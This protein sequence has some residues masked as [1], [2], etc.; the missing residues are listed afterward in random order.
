MPMEEGDLLLSS[1]S[2]NLEIIHVV[3]LTMTPM[4]HQGGIKMP[5]ITSLIQHFKITLLVDRISQTIVA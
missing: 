4:I 2:V 5:H 1:H 3:I